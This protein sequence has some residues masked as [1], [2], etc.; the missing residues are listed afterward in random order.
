MPTRPYLCPNPL[1]QSVSHKAVKLLEFA[2]AVSNAEVVPPSSNYSVEE[3]YHFGKRVAQSYPLGD[4]MD[5][6]SDGYH[7]LWGRPDIG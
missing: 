1:F 6:A 5:F 7:G 3:F 4:E 2:G